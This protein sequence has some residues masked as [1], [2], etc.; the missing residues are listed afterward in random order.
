MITVLRQR[1]LKRA[2]VKKHDLSEEN[3]IYYFG[4]GANLNT[5][6]FLGQFPSAEFI[7][8]GKLSDFSFSINMP[9]EYIGK[10]FGGIEKQRGEVVYG[11][12]YKISK[13]AMHFLNILEW[14]P[15]NFY[16]PELIEV[17]CNELTYQAVVYFPCLVKSDLKTSHGYKDLILKGGSKLNLPS[18]YLSKIQGI[19]TSDTFELDNSFNL[20]SPGKPRLFPSSFYVWHDILREKLC[21]II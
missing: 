15:F 14:V 16:R 13:S 12:L 21:E 5:S 19:R 18:D 20:A 8:V 3:T 11:A 10:G 2:F 7:G 9:C 4:Y 17:S 1:L 6:Y